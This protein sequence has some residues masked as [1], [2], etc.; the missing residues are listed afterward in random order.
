[1]KE[2]EIVRLQMMKIP[3]EQLLV[4][5]EREKNLEMKCALSKL[6]AGIA[7]PYSTAKIVERILIERRWGMAHELEKAQYEQDARWMAE[8]WTA[9]EWKLKEEPDSFYHTTIKDGPPW[10][11]DCSY[12]RRPDAPTKCCRL[13]RHMKTS[14]IC[15]A[16]ENSPMDVMYK[17]ESGGF[18]TWCPLDAEAKQDDP[19]TTTCSSKCSICRHEYEPKPRTIRLDAELPEPQIAGCSSKYEDGK[20]KVYTF[21]V[22]NSEADAEAWLHMWK[23]QVA[24]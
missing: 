18:P 21:M 12:R 11:E 20:H 17:V 24:K 1:M 15:R 2:A 19:H 16:K 14:F 10:R 4:V 3:T 9:W 13:C 8:P 7:K 6:V 5:R 23:E 22:V